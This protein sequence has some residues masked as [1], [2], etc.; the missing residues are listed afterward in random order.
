MPYNLTWK[1]YGA[2]RQY[3]GSVTIT[4]RIASLEA[5]CGDQRFDSL[6]YCITDYSEVESYEITD[7]STAEIAARHI[8]P[9][10]TNPGIAIAAVATRSEIIAA[11]E[12]FKSYSF[13]SAPYCIF[14]TLQEARRWTNAHMASLIG[15]QDL[16]LR[17]SR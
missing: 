13:T 7:A 10:M 3:L 2:F 4:E 9:L 1:R 16:G 5:I 8:G 15:P 17:A 11:I 14:A 12:S 6:C